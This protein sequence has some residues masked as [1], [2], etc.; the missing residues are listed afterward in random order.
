M[1]VGIDKPG[2]DKF[3]PRVDFGGG[4]GQ[5][6]ASLG[7]R[8]DRSAADAD[9]GAGEPVRIDDGPAAHDQIKHARAKIVLPDA[10][11]CSGRV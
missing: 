5:C 8:L 3:V 9:V 10:H 4:C 11:P 6:F 7:D 1:N 2:K